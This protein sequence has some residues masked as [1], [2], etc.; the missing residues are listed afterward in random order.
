MD[1]NWKNLQYSLKQLHLSITDVQS[2]EIE[3]QKELNFSLNKYYKYKRKNLLVVE[4]ASGFL[5]INRNIT[6][7]EKIKVKIN[8]TNKDE[9]YIF[10]PLQKYLFLFRNNLQN[11]FK[12]ISFLDEEEQKQISF[13]LTHFFYEDITLNESSD[14]LNQIYYSLL[15]FELGNSCDSFYLDN[16]INPYSFVYK[17]TQELLKRN[18][19]KI[20]VSYIVEKIIIDL[21]AFIDKNSKVDIFLNLELLIRKLNKKN[22]VNEEKYKDDKD[23]NKNTFLVKC[24][25][26]NNINNTPINDLLKKKETNSSLEKR[27]NVFGIPAHRNSKKLQILN[28]EKI[29]N[30]FDTEYDYTEKTLKHLLKTVDNEIYKLIYLR[31]LKQIINKNFRNMFSIKNFKENIKKF[32]DFKKIITYYNENLKEIKLLVSRLINNIF[33]YRDFVPKLIKT[34]FKAIYSNFHSNFPNDSNFEINI[35][36]INFLFEY[37]IIPTLLYPELNEILVKKKVYKPKIHKN[38]LVIINV[39]RHIAQCKFFV[40]DD[41]KLLNTFVLEQHYTLQ[42]YFNDFLKNLEE[43]IYRDQNKSNNYISN[44]IYQTMCLSP[45]EI[46]IFIKYFN[47]MDFV[48]EK[49]EFQYMTTEIMDKLN[50]DNTVFN[51]YV[52]TLLNYTGERE[53]ALKI[54]K[55]KEKNT[56]YVP[57][58]EE[59]LF[60]ENIKNCINYVLVNVP[61]L[62]NNLNNFAFTS[63]FQH[64]NNEINYHKDEYKDV[65]INKNIPLS[66][67]SNYLINIMERLPTEYS[68]NNYLKLFLEMSNETKEKRE[69]IANKNNLLSL[70]LSGEIFA[71]KKM[72]KIY[73]H[74]LKS[75]KSLELNAKVEYFIQNA[76]LKI[77]L[78]NG[79]ERFNS[80]YNLGG[81]EAVT[82]YIECEEN[83]ILIDTQKGCVH[84]KYENGVKYWT[85][86]NKNK[87][88]NICSQCHVNNINEFIKKFLTYLKSITSDVFSRINDKDYKNKTK[89]NECLEKYIN[90]I[91]DTLTDKWN[92]YFI[93]KNEK[94]ASKKQKV[95]LKKIQSYIL[96]NIGISLCNHENAY[97]ISLKDRQFHEKCMKLNWL[98]PIEHLCINPS[99]I[100]T[101]QIILAKELIDKMD[102]ER[103]GPKIIKYF[104]K[105]VNIIVKMITFTTGRE[106]ISIDDFLP[107]IVYLFILVRPNNAIS[108]YGNATYFLLSDEISENT[109]YSLANIEGCISFINNFSEKNLEK[110]GITKEEYNENCQKC[111]EKYSLREYLTSKSSVI[112]NNNDNEKNNINNVEDNN[113][114]NIKINTNKIND[115]NDV[116]NLDEGLNLNKEEKKKDVNGNVKLENKNENEP[117]KTEGDNINEINTN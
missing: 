50:N 42:N 103:S 97:F 57:E 53:Q 58:G 80:M 99:M 83:E 11:L 100:S 93:S 47:K 67:Y 20:Y 76:E 115:K 102:K 26:V 110:L 51:F 43:D 109:G 78:I 90:F 48:D 10:A 107:I 7:I 62:T 81:R 22:L 13:L 9:M 72:I 86:T 56:S 5:G 25:T 3:M 8:S 64:L 38:L 95:F 88:K 98:D 33:N 44:E 34:A 15:S 75:S 39:L 60:V 113:N 111:M 37:I 45:K 29:K 14:V 108:N 63:L 105:T 36:L 71:F 114:E 31:Q 106:D 6:P 23:N 94:N 40:E 59:M 52:F 74:Q 27:T 1:I 89:A 18:E 68:K 24:E 101:Q 54:E 73:K 4:N 70:D 32:S 12:F 116:E 77:C 35:Y 16:Y 69:K 91:D 117:S 28:E 66:W 21:E 46:E 87:F 92:S 79:K 17:M 49:N 104:S 55:F 19:V 41:Y 82:N 61:P 84:A 65:L 112:N 96:K 85:E 30:I 2:K